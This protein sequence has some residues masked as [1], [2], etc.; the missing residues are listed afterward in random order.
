MISWCMVHGEVESFAQVNGLFLQA[1]MDVDLLE[2]TEMRN[3]IRIMKV[4][5]AQKVIAKQK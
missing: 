2:W 5:R 4:K 3:E 1:G